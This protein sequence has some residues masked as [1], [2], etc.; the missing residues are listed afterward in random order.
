VINYDKLTYSFIY[1][2]YV[3]Q[4]KSWRQ[5]ANENNVSDAILL[6]RARAYG[7]TSRTISQIR[8]EINN[9]NLDDISELYAKGYSIS[10]LTKQYK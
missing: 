9:I 5:I 4:R 10:L 2:Q 6:H 8:S 1:D 3:I 7:I